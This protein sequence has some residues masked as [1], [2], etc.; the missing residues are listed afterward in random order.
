[1]I[2]VGIEHLRYY[3][4]APVISLAES[5]ELWQMMAAVRPEQLSTEFDRNKCRF[6]IVNRTE[7]DMNPKPIFMSSAFL[8]R[9]SILEYSDPSTEVYRLVSTSQVADPASNN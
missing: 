6:L 1:V 4:K 5:R 2:G 3:V 8:N 9:F 7:S